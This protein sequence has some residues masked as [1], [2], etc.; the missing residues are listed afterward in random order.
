[1]KVLV[2][3]AGG[4]LGI[5][6]CETLRERGHIVVSYDRL[7]RDDIRPIDVT[8]TGQV[9]TVLDVN[10]PEVVIH[11]AAWTDVDGAERDPDGAYRANTLGAWNVADAVSRIDACMVY[12]STDFV[13][14]GTKRAPYVEFDR[15]NPLGV[16]GASKEA[17]EQLVRQILPDRHLITRTAW[18]F[19]RHGRCFP[20]T[21]LRLAQTK[22]DI[23]VVADQIGCPTYTVDLARKI[24]ELLADPLPGTYHIV[25]G[26]QC[27]WFEFAQAIVRDAGL[28][29][30]VVPITAEDYAA[31][32]KSPAQ[33]PPYSVLRRLALEMRGMDDLPHWQSALANYFA[34]T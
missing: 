13:F 3:G 7:A 6:V 24:A 17:G 9:R 34:R 28:S 33:R 31:R 27:S 11:C 5:D 22:P 18:L 15:T 21:I 8:D 12:I 19:G 4:L 29:T 10:R 14:D 16:Y 1:M 30:P 25:N 20:N 32:F 2:T 26:G 23:P